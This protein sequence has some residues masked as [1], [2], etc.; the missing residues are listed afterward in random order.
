MGKSYKLTEE[1]KNL[2]A[3]IN[4][5][6]TPFLDWNRESNGSYAVSEGVILTYTSGKPKTYTVKSPK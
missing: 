6:I 2:K 1:E 3:W 5:F 4:Q